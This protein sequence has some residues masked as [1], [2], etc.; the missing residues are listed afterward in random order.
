MDGHHWGI[1]MTAHGDKPMTIDTQSCCQ[2]FRAG[3]SELA[4]VNMLGARIEVEAPSGSIPGLC[5][6]HSD[7]ESGQPF[8]RPLTTVPYGSRGSF[9]E[10]TTGPPDRGVH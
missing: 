7:I 10:M 4:L 5:P 6:R 1:P 9:Y 8:R 2:A 3:M